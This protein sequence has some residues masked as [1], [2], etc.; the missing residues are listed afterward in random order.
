MD[1]RAKRI[2]DFTA[3]SAAIELAKYSAEKGIDT[4][5]IIA[6]MEDKELYPRIASAVAEDS[7]KRGFAEIKEGKEYFYNKAKEIIGLN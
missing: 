1:Y 6:S 4:E 5:H 7:V 3:I 2:D